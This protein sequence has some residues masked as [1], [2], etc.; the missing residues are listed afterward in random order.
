MWPAVRELLREHF[1]KDEEL[2]RND[3]D[4]DL[5]VARGAALLARR[6]LAG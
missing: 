5:V 6:G 2:V 4:P 1:R 3:A